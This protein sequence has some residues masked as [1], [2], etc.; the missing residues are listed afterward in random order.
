M[1]FQEEIWSGKWR[2]EEGTSSNRQAYLGDGNG[3]PR[4]KMATQNRNRQENSLSRCQ[5]FTL[6]SS[7]D[8][9]LYLTPTMCKLSDKHCM[10]QR[11]LVVR[12][13][14]LESIIGSAMKR[15]CDHGPVT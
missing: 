9:G 6:P 3:V 2:G 7:A 14:A 12:T 13:Q 8:H 1:N 5:S 4:S 10:G 11:N 15:L